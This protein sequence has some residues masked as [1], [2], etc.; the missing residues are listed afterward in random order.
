MTLSNIIDTGISGIILNSGS[1]T[2]GMHT[3]L[4]VVSLIICIIL[5]YLLGSV[6]TAI[7]VSRSIYKK[8][9]VEIGS[10]NPGMTNMF[11]SFGKKAGILTFLGD[12]LKTVISIVIGYV[13]FGAFGAYIAGLFC[14]IGH[15]FPIYYKFSGG[16]GVLCTGIMILMTNWKVFLVC[17]AIFCAIV[18]VTKYVSLGS[19]ITAMAYPIILNRNMSSQLQVYGQ[20]AYIVT[21]IS[22]II[23]IIIVLK[24]YKNIKRIMD[25][26][27][28]KFSFKKKNKG[29]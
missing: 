4:F 20:L 9:I 6:N 22:F 15:C 3:L 19:V 18:L 10:K 21:I 11:R 23:M 17:L 25:G 16:K 7:F 24:H 2:D 29:E 26:T 14:V 8:N 5:P 28:N 27:E 12:A 1:L 13:I